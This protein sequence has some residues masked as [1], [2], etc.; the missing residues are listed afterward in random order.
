MKISFSLGN[1]ILAWNFQSRPREFPRIR[2]LAVRLAWKFNS[3]LKV[4]F[5]LEIS[6]PDESLE[7]FQVLCPLGPVLPNPRRPGKQKKNLESG[8]KKPWQPQTWQD[9]TRFSPLDF[10]LLSP[11]FRGLVL[12]NYTENLEKKQ[13]NPVESLQWRRRPEIADFCPLSWSNVSW[14][15]ESRHGLRCY[16]HRKVSTLESKKE[17]GESQLAA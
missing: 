4:S 13:K 17:L 6:I 8:P 12:L 7:M 5:S 2:A 14:W 11:D 3:R 9:L 10:S 15:N 16:G 1:F